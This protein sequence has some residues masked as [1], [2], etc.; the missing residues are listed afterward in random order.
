MLAELELE[1]ILSW[2]CGGVSYTVIFCLVKR[3]HLDEQRIVLVEGLAHAEELLVAVAVGHLVD[4]GEGGLQRL[5]PLLG[6][7]V[8]LA[9]GVAGGERVVLLAGVVSA[10]QV[11]TSHHATLPAFVS[12]NITILCLCQDNLVN[13]PSKL[14]LS[15]QSKH[16]AAV[17]Y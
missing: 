4:A 5:R 1:L 16:N 13:I 10:G 9:R 7:L 15:Q 6:Q 2:D 17:N 3:H 8:G 11:L 12:L 14:K